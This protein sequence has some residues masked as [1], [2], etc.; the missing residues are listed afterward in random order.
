MVARDQPEGVTHYP[1]ESTL[2]ERSVVAAVMRVWEEQIA[3]IPG[4]VM[5]TMEVKP[6]PQGGWLDLGGMAKIDR[7]IF[8]LV[9]DDE[10]LL[11]VPARDVAAYIEHIEWK[12]SQPAEMFGGRNFWTLASMRLGLLLSEEQCKAVYGQLQAI[13]EEA[14]AIANIENDQFNKEIADA[15]LPHVTAPR[16]PVKPMERA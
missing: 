6:A 3:K 10:L 15:D 16:R 7:K 13:V 14:E 9:L 11:T 8:S 4:A 5:A 1:P 2:C 12:L